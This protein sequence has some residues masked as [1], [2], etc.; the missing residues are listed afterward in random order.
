VALLLVLAV[1]GAQGSSFGVM[2]SRFHWM[3][4]L[5]TLTGDYRATGLLIVAI[6]LGFYFT[7]NAKTRFRD[8]WVGAAL[9]G[10]LWRIAF[11]GFAWYVARNK[12]MTMIHGSV[13][14]GVVF[15]VLG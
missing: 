8:V 12:S 1:E 7:P 5:Q 11:S 9:T 10:M 6:G 15:F 14:G 4:L 2:L 3:A 13:A